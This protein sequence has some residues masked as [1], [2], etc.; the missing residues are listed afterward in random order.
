MPIGI[1]SM[2][3]IKAIFSVMVVAK[4][5]VIETIASNV[6]ALHTLHIYVALV[7]ARVC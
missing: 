7:H 6:N 5:L 4:M 2:L 1:N 3:H